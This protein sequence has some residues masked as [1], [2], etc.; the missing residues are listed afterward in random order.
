MID[1]FALGLSHLLLAIAAIRLSMN[2]RL[3]D[4]DGEGGDAETRAVPR[5]RRQAGSGDGTD[6]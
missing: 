1:Y 5:W 3:D 4:D 2:P 6:A